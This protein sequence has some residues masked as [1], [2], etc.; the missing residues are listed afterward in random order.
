MRVEPEPLQHSLAHLF[1][2]DTQSVKQY[3]REGVLNSQTYEEALRPLHIQ[4]ATN[5]IMNDKDALNF[6]KRRFLFDE[7]AKK[8]SNKFPDSM[9]LMFFK[10]IV[11]FLCLNNK[12][13]TLSAISAI[14]LY[15]KKS[16]GYI[17]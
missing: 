9:T 2:S 1:Q 13:L 3:E 15:A 8:S 14:H 11:A 7:I 16:L 10:A 17:A 4:V 5:Q 6:V 12:Y